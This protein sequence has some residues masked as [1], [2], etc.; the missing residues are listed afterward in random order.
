MQTGYFGTG[1][2]HRDAA[3]RYLRRKF[4]EGLP[5]PLAR[6]PGARFYVTAHDGRR[7]VLLLGPFVS[8][9]TARERAEPARRLLR[10]RYPF[11]AVSTASLPD[12]RPTLF[13]RFAPHHDHPPAGGAR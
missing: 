11:A 8:H 2:R 5:E 6:R 9:M 4:N 13:G 7:T 3:K 10:A 1:I 12:S